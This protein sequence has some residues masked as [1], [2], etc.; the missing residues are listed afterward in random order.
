MIAN[1]IDNRK[2]KPLKKEKRILIVARLFPNKGVQD[3][4]DALKGVDLEG[5]QVD[6]VGDGPYRSFLEKKTKEKVISAVKDAPAVYKKLHNVR[7][8][9]KEVLEDWNWIVIKSSIPKN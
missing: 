6:I 4:L 1:G 5:W 2:F 8:N 9:G 3:I 7:V